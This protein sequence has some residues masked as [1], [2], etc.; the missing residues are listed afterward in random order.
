M[1]GFCIGTDGNSYLPSSNPSTANYGWIQDPVTLVGP[2]GGKK[3]N[4][5]F[6]TPTGANNLGKCAL[7]T[8][9]VLG[10]TV[11]GSGG[12]ELHSSGPSSKYGVYRVTGPASSK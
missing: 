10:S 9:Q 12:L 5:L 2:I 1:P 3:Y 7:S 8:A 4:Q 11:T 6:F